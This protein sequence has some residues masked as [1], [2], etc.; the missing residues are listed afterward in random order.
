MP[1]VHPKGR[2]L[3]LSHRLHFPKIVQIF[4][5]LYMYSPV[6]VFFFTYPS[7]E[8]YEHL[9]S[10]AAVSVGNDRPSVIRMALPARRAAGGRPWPLGVSAQS[11]DRVGS[12]SW[13]RLSPSVR[14]AS[15]AKASC[16]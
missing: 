1:Q 8:V 3:L 14:A 12:S 10:G 15:A 11:S 16:R 7:V 9:S 4:V 13:L 2:T 6:Q 5:G